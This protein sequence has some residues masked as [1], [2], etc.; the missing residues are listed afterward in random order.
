MV[1]RLDENHNNLRAALRWSWRQRDATLLRLVAAL[2]GWCGRLFLAEGQ[3]WVDRAMA[4]G[5]DAPTLLRAHAANA[6]AEYRKPAPTTSKRSASGGKASS[7]T[8]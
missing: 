7:S 1:P 5:D 4:I 2:A 8:R 3:A 6:A